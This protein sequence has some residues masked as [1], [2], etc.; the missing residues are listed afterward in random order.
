MAKL[1]GN[2]WSK[3]EQNIFLNSLRPL[4][5]TEGIIDSNYVKEALS[6]F[7]NDYNIKF[8]CL[9]FNGADN[10]KDFLQL[11][12]EINKTKRKII[13]LFDRDKKGQEN[14]SKIVTEN[15]ENINLDNSKVFR[16]S[17]LY[18]LML[19]KTK[20][21]QSNEFLIEDYFSSDAK[22]TCIE[23]SFNSISTD[24]CKI[25]TNFQKTVKSKLRKTIACHT[26]ECM[27]GF[28]VLLETIKNIINEEA[29][30]TFEDF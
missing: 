27:T 30:I 5:L 9:S 13:V 21:H 8:D 10:A 24:F 20:E 23:D 12:Q 6:L 11:I 25:P 29:T 3:V 22:K 4:V 1:T 19:P 26:P 14:L 15:N 2:I 17:N 18:L 7:K 28:R 16:K